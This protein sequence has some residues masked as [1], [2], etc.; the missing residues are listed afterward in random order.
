[1]ATPYN[2]GALPQPPRKFQKACALIGVSLR[3]TAI[4]LHADGAL[5]YSKERACKNLRRV[6]RRAEAEKEPKGKQ[7]AKA[8]QNITSPVIGSNILS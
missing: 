2:T 5:P 1:M 6:T 4:I 7:R 8:Y 3:P